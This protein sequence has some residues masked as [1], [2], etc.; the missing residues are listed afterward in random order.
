MKGLTHLLLSVALIVVGSV[1]LVVGLAQGQSL[2]ALLGAGLAAVA[3]VISLLL[4]RGVIGQRSGLVIGITLC[5]LAIG[6]AYVN[7]RRTHVSVFHFGMD[8]RSLSQFQ[9][10]GSSSLMPTSYA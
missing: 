3:G 2:G 5:A 7:Y 4:Q 9:I 1:L 6:L 10:C 8:Q